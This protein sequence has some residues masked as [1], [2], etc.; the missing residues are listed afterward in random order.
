MRHRSLA[1]FVSAAALAA[2][3]FGGPA[4]S[5]EYSQL[6]SQVGAQLKSHSIEVPDLNALTG[7]QLGQLSLIMS[8][9]VG[10]DVQA[11]QVAALLAV[12]QECIGNEQMRST[13][14]GQL[15]QHNFEVKNFDKI[16]G[17]ELVLLNVILSSN[18]TPQQMGAQIEKIFAEPSPV[19]GSD[20]LRVETARCIAKVDAKVQNF[21]ALTPDQMVQMAS[22]AALLRFRL[23]AE[24][25]GVALAPSHLGALGRL[26]LGD[27]AGV[28][29]HDAD[30]AGMGDHHHPPRPVRVH[31]EHEL[32]H[33]DH[34]VARG[35][36]V[37]EQQHA[38]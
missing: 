19:T 29:G 15:R 14:A 36:I 1:A 27:V 30:P 13:V 9:N 34:E 12:D 4:F 23:G 8:T 5:D 28:D 11:K 31:A 6:R 35:E 17:S 25:E 21:D 10:N 16:S 38:V 32:Q 22:A 7:E 24:G 3:V 37:V 18:E 33:P 26:G 2:A 20:Q